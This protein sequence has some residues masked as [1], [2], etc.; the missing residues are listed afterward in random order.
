MSKKN[1]FTRELDKL[2]HERTY[3]LR[4]SLGNTKPGHPP[5]FTC[6]K[7]SRGIEK[8]QWIA[9]DILANKLAK[10]EFSKHAPLKR[11]WRVKGHGCDNKKALFAKWYNRV[12]HK[13]HECVYV[14][15]GNDK[16]IYIGRTGNGAKR[17]QDHFDS[18]SKFS[19]VIKIDIYSVHSPSQL[20]KLECLAIHRF[21]PTRNKM[22]AANKKWTK[23]CPVCD[24]HK[25]IQQELRKIFRF[26]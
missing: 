24:F 26:K 1:E 21:L 11:S 9:S 23:K 10:S 4:S 6:D 12:V 16:C 19:G 17:P 15:W 18:K 22:K 2:F 8:L 14:F 7:V 25:D 3:W 20:P 5:S 13:K